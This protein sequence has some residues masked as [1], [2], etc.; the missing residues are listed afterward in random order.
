MQLGA[1]LDAFSG[2]VSGNRFERLRVAYPQLV[3][4]EALH[5]IEARKGILAQLAQWAIMISESARVAD[6]VINFWW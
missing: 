4:V 6:S 2:G 5:V 1:A 3:A